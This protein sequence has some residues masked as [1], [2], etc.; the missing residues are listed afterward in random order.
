MTETNVL[1]PIHDA[2]EEMV[3]SESLTPSVTFEV[4]DQAH[5]HSINTTSGFTY[6][7][8][9]LFDAER[10]DILSRRKGALKGYMSDE[11]QLVDRLASI[12]VRPMAT[13]PKHAWRNLMREAGLY[14]FHFDSDGSLK[15][16]DPTRDMKFIDVFETV[17]IC[18]FGAIV[19]TGLMG[20]A[21]IG[22]VSKGGLSG[23]LLIGFMGTVV[24]FAAGMFWIMIASIFMSQEGAER[25]KRKR[26]LKRVSKMSHEESLE[27]L[28]PERT[29]RIQ[30]TDPEEE[31][32][33]NVKIVLPDPPEDVIDIIRAVEKSGSFGPGTIKVATVAEAIGFFPPLHKQVEKETE[34]AYQGRLELAKML[35]LLDP[36]LYLEFGSAIAVIAQFGEFAIEQ[37]LI[38]R[39]ANTPDYLFES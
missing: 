20:G 14:D 10:N 12:G 24:G 5:A 13:A 16:M 8:P 3:R 2:I 6:S 38:E 15:A 4:L 9:K 35:D 11:M 37:D 34:I 29:S 7:D 32:V 28:W 1:A 17:V 21:T 26:H 31:D 19:L 33:I 36:I 30:A 23:A 18:I 27:S 39:V 25:V 22:F